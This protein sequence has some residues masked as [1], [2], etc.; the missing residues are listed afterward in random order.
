MPH[1][2][3][4]LPT[5]FQLNTGAKIPA[6]GFGTWQAAPKEVESAV[7]CALKEGYRH[8]DCAAIY[9]NETEVGEGIRKS[10]VPREDIF[11]TGKL[12]NT[13]H[14][15]EDVESALD[16]TLK[17]LGTDYVDL[18]LMHWPCAFASGDKFFPLDSEGVFKLADIDYVATYK[19]MEKLLSTGKAR[20]VGVSNFNIRRLEDLL[21]KTDVVPACNQVEAHPYLTQPDLLEFCNKHNIILEAYSPLGNNQTGEPR[22]VDDPLV[23]EVAKSLDMD[24]GVVLGSWGVQRGHVVL[25]KSVTPSRIASNLQVK[26]LPQEAFEKLTSLARHKRFNFP[27][28]WG[29]DIFDE[30]GQDAVTKAARAAGEENRT[31]FTVIFGPIDR[32]IAVAVFA[33][34]TFVGPVAGPIVGGFITMSHLG[35][36]WTAWITLIM[37]GFFGLIGFVVIPETLAPVLLSRRAKKIR[38]ATKNWAIHAK[39]DENEVNMKELAHRYLLKP[40]QML[41]MEPILLLVTLYMG[42]IYGF[43]YLCFEAY[44]I[45]FQQERGWNAGVGALPFAAIIVGVAFGSIFICF[46]TK[47]RFARKMK[48]HGEVVPE[49]RMIPMIVG[50]ALLP[51]GMFWF[52]WTSNPNIIWVPQVIS[53][54]FIGAGVLL[55]F[56]QGLNYIIDVYKV[57]ANSA[58]AANT[59][60]RSW[61]GAGFPMFATSMFN[62]LGVPWAMSLLGFLTLALFPVPI[63][64]FIY[65]E[66]IRKLSKFSA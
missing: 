55:V 46:F 1:A 52:A 39:A 47:T 60:F 12:W 29:Y 13:K 37:A 30:A 28:R 42:F 56:L 59:F 61:L 34:A 32:G 23:H 24:P 45:A 2:D 33:S 20:A 64:F 57:N 16:K 41:A 51:I 35:W 3:N 21:S 38:F 49:E 48:E 65:G 17:D 27:A 26:K 54:A 62:T 18:Y 15:P 6:V 66:K 10:G 19:A 31:K 43:L 58:I 36:R 22:T 25:P 63:L 4:Q 44:P 7:E 11:I 53:G 50:G 8:I 40:F 14:A 5:H 9:R